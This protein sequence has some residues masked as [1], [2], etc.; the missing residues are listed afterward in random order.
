MRC[1]I[2]TRNLDFCDYGIGSAANPLANCF[3]SLDPFSFSIAM[4]Q[5]NSNLVLSW[6]CRYYAGTADIRSSFYRP[7]RTVLIVHFFTLFNCW[8]LSTQTFW[9]ISLFWERL[10]V[11]IAYLVRDLF[12]EQVCF[13][14]DLLMFDYLCSM[15][16]CAIERFRHA[17][18]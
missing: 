7:T 8:V 17:D 15:E 4:R 11:K 9:R 3:R 13:V 6:I 18:A 12:L 14:V 16:K 2:Q 5:R 1:G 10:T